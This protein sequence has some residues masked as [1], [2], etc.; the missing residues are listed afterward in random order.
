[1]NYDQSET[2]KRFYSY[3]KVSS[4]GDKSNNKIL[5]RQFYQ[6]HGYYK[7]ASLYMAGNYF[8]DPVASRT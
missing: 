4:Q 1:M 2:K 6:E 8:C 5:F 7:K 3:H